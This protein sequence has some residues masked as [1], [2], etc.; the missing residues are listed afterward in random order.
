MGRFRRILGIV[1]V[2]IFNVFVVN[3]EVYFLELIF[4]VFISGGCWFSV[5]VWVIGK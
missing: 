1:V 5:K 3:I 4:I 2:N